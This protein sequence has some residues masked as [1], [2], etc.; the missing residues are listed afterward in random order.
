MEAHLGHGK[1]KAVTN[2][3]ENTRNGT[4]SKALKGEFG[5][6]PIEIPRECQGS[7][8]EKL[9]CSTIFNRPSVVS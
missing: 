3:D 6:L 8:V 1:N 4:S 9:L 5:M 7:I 2:S